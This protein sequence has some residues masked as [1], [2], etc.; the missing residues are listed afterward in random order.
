MAR[1]APML[2]TRHLLTLAAGATIV[3]LALPARAAVTVLG[4]NMAHECSL[5]AINGDTDE[6]A[7][8]KCTQALDS[9]FLSLRDRAGTFVNRGVLKLRRKEFAA[10]QGDFNLAIET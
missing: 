8:A 6:T 5:A 3:A 2:K 10:A 1:S 7:E 4:G 9:E